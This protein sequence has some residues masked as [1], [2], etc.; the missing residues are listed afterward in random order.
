[1]T[2]LA[3]AVSFYLGFKGNAAYDRLSEA[4]KI[5]GGGNYPDAGGTPL[6][7]MEAGSA[8]ERRVAVQPGLVWGL[9]LAKGWD[10]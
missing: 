6:F 7:L 3:T 10:Q 9:D 5:W 8:R 4:R 1:M 2:I